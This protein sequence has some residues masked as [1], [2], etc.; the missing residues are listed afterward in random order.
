MKHKDV[1]IHLLFTFLFIS[2]LRIICDLLMKCDDRLSIVIVF[3]S[4]AVV[5]RRQS[6]RYEDEDQVENKD[7]QVEKMQKYKKM[8][9]TSPFF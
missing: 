8:R 6:R 7:E 3:C 1:L 4:H 2:L 5:K 9:S